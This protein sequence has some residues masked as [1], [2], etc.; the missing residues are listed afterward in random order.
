MNTIEAK[1]I[2]KIIHYCWFG[3]GKL[4]E[5]AQK[6]IESW[7][8][9]CPT[10]QIIEWNEDN[11]NYQKNK[12]IKQA[13]ESK[14]WS[15]VTDY[16]RLDV[17]NQYGGIYFDVDVELLKSLDDLLSYNAFFGFEN[18]SYVATGLGFGA[19]PNQKIV[20]DMLSIYENINFINADGSLNQ[21]TCPV[22]NTQ[23]IK[24]YGFI[25]N[26]KTQINENICVLAPEY[27]A[28]YNYMTGDLNITNNTYSVHW[29]NMSWKSVQEKKY[30]KKI[31]KVYKRSNVLGWWYEHIYYFLKYVRERGIF[32][33]L[34]KIINKVKKNE[35]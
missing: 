33:T 25:I 15:F 22:Y 23:I 6:C 20:E 13:Y 32:F 11:Y 27:L 24:K 9:N 14:K 18:V 8:R 35:D 21:I 30:I 7:K 34:K 2:P 17:I 31:Q 16:V 26:G 5:E 19:L 12:Y 10:Y 28:P 4:P 29:Y 1:E 3:K